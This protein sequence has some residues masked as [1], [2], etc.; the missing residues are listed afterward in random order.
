MPRF[1]YFACEGIYGGLHGVYNYGV[2]DAYNE[3]DVR[4]EAINASLEIINSYSSICESL[5]SDV[6]YRMEPGDNFDELYEEACYE[7]VVYGLWRIDENKA[8]NFS[9]EELNRMSCSMGEDEFVKRFC[10]IE[11]I[12]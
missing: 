2:I 1:F 3:D 12:A 9:T 10:I 4:N 6:E 11:P 5:K 7:D 8:K